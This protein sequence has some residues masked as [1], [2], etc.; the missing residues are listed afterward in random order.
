MNPDDNKKAPIHSVIIRSSYFNSAS[1]NLPLAVKR[2]LGPGQVI[3]T[4][5]PEQTP[6][7][8]GTLGKGET[9]IQKPI[10][11]KA[12]YN[13]A[14]P[15]LPELPLQVGDKFTFEIKNGRIHILSIVKNAWRPEAQPPRYQP[16][17]QPLFPDQQPPPKLPENPEASDVV[18]AFVQWMQTDPFQRLH[19]YGDR[20]VPRGTAKRGSGWDFRL[21]EFSYT[22]S[23]VPLF[24]QVHKTTAPVRQRLKKLRE[25]YDWSQIHEKDQIDKKDLQQLEADAVWMADWAESPQKKGFAEP[26]WAVF[27]SAVTATPRMEAPLTPPWTRLA[28]FASEGLPEQLTAWDSRIAASVIY[29]LDQIL[30]ANGLAPENFENFIY[31]RH[32]PA[33][34]GTRPRPLN[35]RWR[36]G[37]PKALDSA[38]VHYFMISQFVR[39]ILAALNDPANKIP[40]MPLPDGGEADWDMF[41]LNLVL[42][43]DGY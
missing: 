24:A 42:F 18:R 15:L 38:W 34:G 33:I 19:R 39:D 13:E 35:L 36:S 12:A 41:D 21:K 25:K 7:F 8:T 20:L 26:A 23:W 1:I 16:K 6:V 37:F 4:A 27:A 31:L 43:M 11:C 3:F 40:R 5:G 14:H 9:G 29:R 2:E 10:Y 28:A 30:S 17:A 32:L 22:R